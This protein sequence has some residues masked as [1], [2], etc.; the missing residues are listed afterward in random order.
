MYT[1]KSLLTFPRTHTNGKPCPCDTSTSIFIAYP[2]LCIIWLTAIIKTRVCCAY[3]KWMGKAAIQLVGR[4]FCSA[5]VWHNIHILFPCVGREVGYLHM[6]FE[7]FISEM[8]CNFYSRKFFS[9]I[10]VYNNSIVGHFALVRKHQHVVQTV[11]CH[12]SIFLQTVYKH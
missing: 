6:Y 7:N 12:L 9:T 4:L 8:K 1:C 11:S 10:C 2:V 3:I 5:D